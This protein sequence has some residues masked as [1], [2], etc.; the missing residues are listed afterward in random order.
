MTVPSLCI[1]IAENIKQKTKGQYKL[2]YSHSEP[3]AGRLMGY[4]I[5]YKSVRGGC[6]TNNYSTSDIRKS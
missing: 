4:L 3:Q 6:L 5:R 1:H 2:T